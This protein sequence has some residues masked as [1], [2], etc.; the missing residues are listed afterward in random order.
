MNKGFTHFEFGTEEE[1]EVILNNILNN[2]QWIIE[3]HNYL[4]R[5]VD[6]NGF[7][8]EKRGSMEYEVPCLI[9]T[10]SEYSMSHSKAA[11]LLTRT[12]DHFDK[13]QLLSFERE[14]IVLDL[15]KEIV[16]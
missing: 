11:S 13:K 15:I 1:Q 5:D 3:R 14:D 7:R 10:R 8:I 12:L 9:K 6:T 4:M 2:K 16:K